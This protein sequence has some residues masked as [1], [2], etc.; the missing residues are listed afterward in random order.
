M[1]PH[2][3]SIGYLETRCTALAGPAA[4][5]RMGAALDRAFGAALSRA[6]TR[7]AEPVLEGLDGVVRIRRLAVRLDLGDR[8]EEGGI[9]SGLAARIAAALRTALARGGGEVRVWPDHAAYLASYLMR[10]LGLAP[11][12]DWPFAELAKLDH[13]PAERAAAELIRVRPEIL[14]PLGR[15]AARR[16]A[17][18]AAV[19]GWP[20]AAQ[21]EL[22]LALLRSPWSPADNAALL[23]ALRALAPALP[24]SAPIEG[25]QALAAAVLPLALRVLARASAPVACRAVVIAAAAFLAAQPSG[26]AHLVRPARARLPGS[27]RDPHEAA[28]A[29]ALA[30]VRR[31]PRRRAALDELLARQEGTT[32]RAAATIETERGA[33]RKEQRSPQEGA[34]LRTPFAG[35]GLLWPAAIATGAAETLSPT[36]L[37][38][39]VWQALDAADW[40]AAA[41]DPALA[42]L[43]PADPRAIDLTRA[44]SPPPAHLIERL[45][46][47][48]RTVCAA[49]RAGFG[50]SALLLG[51]LASR[52]RG[53]RG[54]TQGWL[55]MQFLRRP[56]S[57]DRG[58]DAVTIR[59]DPVPLGVVLRMAGFHGPQMR[60]PQPGAR[61]LVL[62][63][64]GAG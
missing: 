12:P 54:S 57:V 19:A 21:A 22:A 58:E 38:Q 44:Q 53:L 56:G 47:A 29:E 59:L 55:R 27:P 7:A 15:E 32:A 62:D 63:L 18:E 8:F 20:E 60:L 49:A 36:A 45:D 31:E 11:G 50:W 23:P 33:Q 17:P 2:R 5:A 43:F 26:G 10:R 1:D 41:E 42:L 48:A 3:L 61:R 37:A 30:L 39:A 9:A 46:P 28:L 6:L 4:A 24:S 14:R 25:R 40:D 35:L 13:L 64:G 51:D 34:P 16:G 52:L